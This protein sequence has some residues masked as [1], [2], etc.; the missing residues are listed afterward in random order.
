MA[1]LGIAQCKIQ[2][3]TTVATTALDVTISEVADVNKCL[4]IINS[5]AGY[6]SGSFVSA[7][8][9]NVRS[10]AS[11]IIDWQLIEFGGAV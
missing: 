7:T 6:G 1:K 10:S 2:K 3:G 11:A 9:I 5:R 4:L 8:K